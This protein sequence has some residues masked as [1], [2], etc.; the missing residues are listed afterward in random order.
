MPPVTFDN[1][2]RGRASNVKWGP[3]RTGDILDPEA[4]DAAFTTYKPRSVIHFAALAYVSESVHD[5]LSYYQVRAL[6]ADQS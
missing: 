6:M 2:S 5:P 3:L 1:L 4:L